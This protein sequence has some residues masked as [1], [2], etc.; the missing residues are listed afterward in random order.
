MSFIHFGSQREDSRVFIPASFSRTANRRN[1]CYVRKK[2]FKGNKPKGME[3]LHGLI[4]ILK[5]ACVLASYGCGF[6]NS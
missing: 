6:R 4:H 1:T 2:Q 5:F 3:T